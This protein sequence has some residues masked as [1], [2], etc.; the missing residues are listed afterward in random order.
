MPTCRRPL[1]TFILCL[2]AHATLLAL[3]YHAHNPP[4]TLAI[5]GNHPRISAIDV[6]IDHPQQTKKIKAINVLQ[7]SKPHPQKPR[8]T[9]KRHRPKP[10]QRTT[11][12]RQPIA[13]HNKTNQEKATPQQASEAMIAGVHYDQLIQRLYRHIS[14]HQIKPRCG[15]QYWQHATTVMRFTLTPTGELTQIKIQQKSQLPCIDQAAVETL[16]KS[17]QVKGIK[18]TLRH[19]LTFDLPIEFIAD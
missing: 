14:A 16:K 15:T 6:R 7:T 1:L 5:K 12:H 11:A 17:G 4:N 9:H 8:V 18:T 10:A 13:D 3:L 19:Q 2:L